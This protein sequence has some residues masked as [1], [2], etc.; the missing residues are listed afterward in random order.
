QVTA[1]QPLFLHQ[2]QVFQRFL[3]LG[4]LLQMAV[5]HRQKSLAQPGVNLAQDSLKHL[6]VE[7]GHS[8]SFKIDMASGRSKAAP[9]GVPALLASELSLLP[10]LCLG[11]LM[12][13]ASP[14]SFNASI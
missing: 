2:E 9:R 1:D 12:S 5:V 4:D 3:F 11:V 14:S 10:S 13:L 8:A 7:G 6:L